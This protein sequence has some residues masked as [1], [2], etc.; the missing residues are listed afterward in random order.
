M[1]M[2]CLKTVLA[3]S[4]SLTSFDLTLRELRTLLPDLDVDLPDLDADLADLPRRPWPW[5]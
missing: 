5:P 2:D 4:A 1:V 3:I